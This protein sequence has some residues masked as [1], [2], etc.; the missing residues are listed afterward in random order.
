MQRAILVLSLLSA[1]AYL[2]LSKATVL[3]ELAVLHG[4]QVA[5]APVPWEK[6]QFAAI[7]RDGAGTTSNTFERA[8]TF[9]R[10]ARSNE[11][12]SALAAMKTRIKE[13]ADREDFKRAD[14]L[15]Q[16]MSRSRLVDTA[17]VAD[18]VWLGATPPLAANET[19]N[20]TAGAMHDIVLAAWG[21]LV[22]GEA[23]A[24]SRQLDQ[25]EALVKQIVF[26][27]AH[28]GHRRVSFAAFEETSG[29]EDTYTWTIRREMVGAAFVA[30]AAAYESDQQSDAGS[31]P[32]G[33]MALRVLNGEEA[34]FYKPP[35]SARTFN[36]VYPPGKRLSERPSSLRADF[37]ER[38]AGTFHKKEA[39]SVAPRSPF[40]DYIEKTLIPSSSFANSSSGVV[41]VQC[42]RAHAWLLGHNAGLTSTLKALAEDW[43]DAQTHLKVPVLDRYA[44]TSKEN[45]LRENEPVSLR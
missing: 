17:D 6:K 40:G 37:A 44:R 30:R 18:D 21:N 13:A 35:T 33:H 11:T 43:S 38:A 31:D 42:G 20:M 23:S 7:L 34:A 9:E 2:P 24:K 14:S 25:A 36:T 15:K 22:Q 41:R 1:A 12:G 16:E 29:A 28:L 8:N 39:V 5:A 10:V 3:G 32:E 4:G 26:R 45:V 19:I 27:A